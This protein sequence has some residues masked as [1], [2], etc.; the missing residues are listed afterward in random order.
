MIG[1]LPTIVGINWTTFVSL[2]LSRLDCGHF[3]SSNLTG[4]TSWEERQAIT[5]TSSI[6]AWLS[7]TS[8]M[9]PS[10]QANDRLKRRTPPRFKRR[11]QSLKHWT[12]RTKAEQ[13][14]QVPR[15]DVAL[16]ISISQIDQGRN[17]RHGEVMLVFW[18]TALWMGQRVMKCNQKGIMVCCLYQTE[19]ILIAP[20]SA[21]QENGKHLDYWALERKRNYLEEPKE[22][23][24]YL[25]G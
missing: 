6:H 23:A 11:R 9:G 19:D 4:S 16:C 20:T 14:L 5:G 24:G 15:A 10:K 21:C 8:L 12:E 1:A 17:L 3:F 2:K 25:C 18:D 7:N 13:V 22:E